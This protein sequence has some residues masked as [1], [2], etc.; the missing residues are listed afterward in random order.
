MVGLSR[1]GCDVTGAVSITWDARDADA[2]RQAMTPPPDAVVLAIGGASGS[3]SNRTDVTKA[4]LGALPDA[5]ANARVIVHSSLGV[6]DSTAFLPA[7]LRPVIK[8][9]LGKAL[10]DHATQEE[11]VK[12]AN[13]PWTI[14]RPGG[15]RD[16]PATGRIVASETPTRM[17]KSIPRAD[18]AAFILDCIADPTTAGRAYGLGVQRDR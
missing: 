6:G 3:S 16:T 18:V 17:N 14:V 4:V 10:A 15:L 2:L 12:N 11:A 9:A 1:R 13:N 7:P 8:L 5:N